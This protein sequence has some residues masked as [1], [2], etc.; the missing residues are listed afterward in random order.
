LEAN[1]FAQ[2]AEANLKMKIN[3]V[4]LAGKKGELDILPRIFSIEQSSTYNYSHNFVGPYVS[5][6]KHQLLKLRQLR[7]DSK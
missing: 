1:D 2:L 3:F 5:N 4:V 7:R 6:Q